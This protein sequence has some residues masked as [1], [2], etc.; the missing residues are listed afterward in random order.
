MA[1]YVLFSCYFMRNWGRWFQVLR[2]HL[3]AVQGNSQYAVQWGVDLRS[4]G[5]WSWI[6]SRMMRRNEYGEGKA[7]DLKQSTT[8]VKCG[9]HGHVILMVWLLM[10]AAVCILKLTERYLLLR[11]S[12]VPVNRLV[13]MDPKHSTEEQLKGFVQQKNEMFLNGWFSPCFL[14]THKQTATKGTRHLVISIDSRQALIA[15]ALELRLKVLTV[16]SWWLHH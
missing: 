15:K 16:K 4:R 9:E 14:L 5:R 11:F 10:K 3:A 13:Q 2:L 12:Y 7:H 8:S 6:S 1:S